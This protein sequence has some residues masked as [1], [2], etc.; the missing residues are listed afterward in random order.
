[1]SYTYGCVRAI[2]V[3]TGYAQVGNGFDICL[4]KGAIE[5]GFLW[6]TNAIGSA[7]DI[8]AEMRLR[9]YK[10]TCCHAPVML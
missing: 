8:R 3:A 10:Y 6:I 5:R 4:A 2:S 7:L 1:M 9:C